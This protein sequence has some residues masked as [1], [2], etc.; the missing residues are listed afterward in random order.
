MIGKVVLITGAT[1]GLGKETARALARMGATVIAH[2]RNPAKA[3]KTVREIQRE[4]GNAN[5]ATLLADLSSLQQ[6]RDL[7]AQFKA[8]HDR[9]DVLVNNAG[10]AFLRRRETVD[11]YEMTFALNHLSMFLLTNL[12]LDVIRA[13]APARIVNM[14]SSAHYRGHIDFDDLQRARKKYRFFDAYGD[15]K[16]ANVLFTYELARRLDGTGVTAN[17]LHPGFVSTNI[18]MNNIP[19]LG[20]LVR[21]VIMPL[22][23]EKNAADGARTGIY[24]TSAPEVEG[25]TGKFFIDEQETRSSDESYNEDVQRRL[26]AVSE[27]LTGLA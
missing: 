27:A 13:S 20:G 1:D 9:L 5:V 15:S 18:G 8:T 11:G 22:V 24:L 10:A 17:A 16:L 12:L 3:A 21:R 19:L 4:T 23:T 6:T 26:W 14:A 7:A 2:G 25:V